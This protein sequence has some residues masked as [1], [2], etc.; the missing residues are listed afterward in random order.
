MSHLLPTVVLICFQSFLPFFADEPDRMESH[1]I[2]G[3]AYYRS[4]DNANALLEYH[5]A[6]AL[7]PDSFSTLLRMARTY[8]DMGRLKLGVDSSSQ[9]FYQKAV[10]YAETMTRLYPNRPESHFWLA[11][12]KGSLIRFVGVGDKIRIGKE[13]QE[14]ARK[15]IELDSTF[16]HA[17]IILAIFQREGAKL[18]WIEKTIVRIVFGHPI[19]G[20]LED[21]ERFLQLALT[22]DRKNSYAFYEMYWTYS[23]MGQ[24]DK[25][26]DALRS[27]CEIPPTNAREQQQRDEALDILRNHASFRSE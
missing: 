1:L 3:D 12:G 11:L 14:E 20:S 9:T 8:N 27:L 15:A 22:Y 2:K 7:A 19:D 4:F 26:L 24:S 5:K 13:V 18:S 10:E 23:A 17:Y 21:S 6:F 16:S 25:A